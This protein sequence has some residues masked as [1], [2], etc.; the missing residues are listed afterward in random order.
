MP[1]SAL[2]KSA[3]VGVRVHINTKRLDFHDAPQRADDGAAARP[4]RV[5]ENA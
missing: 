3:P 2:P 5:N 4:L 1:G